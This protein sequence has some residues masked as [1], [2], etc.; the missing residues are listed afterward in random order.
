MIPQVVWFKRDLRLH[1]HAPLT[2]AAARGA[3]LPLYVFEP[4]LWQQ[5]DASFRHWAFIRESL[6]ELDSSLR[7]LGGE[8]IV[9]RGSIISVLAQLHRDLGRFD[10][11]SHE[12]TGNGWS[13]ARDREVTRWCREQGIEWIESP[14]NGVVRRLRER[15]GWSA[16]RNVVMTATPLPAPSMILFAKV[17]SDPLP[18]VDAAP[19]YRPDGHVQRG[20]RRDGLRALKS[21]LASRSLGY[22]RSISKP[23]ISARHCSRLSAHLAY[24]T[25][26]A[27]EVDQAAALR[28]Q[29]LD[30]SNDPSS[31]YWSRQIAAFRARLAWR[32]HFVQKLEQQPQIEFRCMHPAF[33]SMRD[34]GWRDDFFEAWRQ[35]HTGFPLI[36]ACMRSLQANGWITFRMRALLVSFASY[37]LWLD[38][39][40][41]GPV[42][43]RLFTDYEPGIHYSQLQMQSGVTGINAV[44]LYNPVKQ[45][46]EH[47]PEGRFIRRYVPELAT[48]PDEFIHEPWQLASLPSGYPARIVDHEQA[49]REARARMRPYWHG[50]SFR[51]QAKAVF[52]KLGSRNR[53]T[54]QRKPRK[55]ASEPPEAPQ[56]DLEF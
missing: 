46:R 18:D 39:R 38:W 19:F 43:A 25:L 17:A 34:T 44:R 52:Q 12:E 40:R 26:S 33:E 14:T 21:F 23:G 49:A 35:G 15:D 55:A 32:C 28:M 29:E 54:E 11:H 42:L 9:R 1:D 5:A 45:S 50:D 20:G 36:D 13:Y 53:R 27:R 22:M 10:L 6:Q 51:E 7:G 41:T 30:A 31:T 47:D 24:G 37:Q 56:L 48:V 4:Q 8:L 2:A 16:A 3:V